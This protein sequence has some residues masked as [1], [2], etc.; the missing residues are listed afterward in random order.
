MTLTLLK[1]T[2][3]L[4][5]RMSLN[6]GLSDISSV[7]DLGN[8]LLGRKNF[9]CTLL[10]RC[11]GAC[12]KRQINRR[13]GIQFLL[14]F[15]RMG[16]HRKEIKLKEVVR[17]RSLYTLL[18]KERRFELQGMINRGEVTRKYMGKLMEDKVC[19]HKCIIA[20]LYLVQGTPSSKENLLDFRQIRGGQRILPV[21]VDFHLSSA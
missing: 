1:I 4:F 9:S 8:A 14:I 15:T 3:Q 11:L 10:I 2:G 19:L 16:F 21:Y 18:T 7:L 6:L 5:D 20:L 13:K 12:D 17:L